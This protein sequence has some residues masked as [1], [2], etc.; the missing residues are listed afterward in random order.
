[1]EKMDIAEIK[2]SA[3]IS[4]SA[5]INASTQNHIHWSK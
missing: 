4:I 1:M 5:E 3:Q 2:S